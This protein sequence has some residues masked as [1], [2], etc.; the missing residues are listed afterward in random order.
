MLSFAL[1]LMLLPLVL[2]TT[3]AQPA[4]T[5]QLENVKLLNRLEA[6]LEQE[7]AVAQG[8]KKVLAYW[9]KDIC[10]PEGDD[11]NFDICGGRAGRE[12]GCPDT[13]EGRTDLCASGKGRKTVE[14]KGVIDGCKYLFY[15][16]YE[17]I[18]AKPK[19]KDC[20]LGDVPTAADCDASCGVVSQKIKVPAIGNGACKPQTYS[21]KPQDGNCPS[22]ALCYRQN[23]GAQGCTNFDD[24]LMSKTGAQSKDACSQNCAETRGCVG[25]EWEARFLGVFGEKAC[26]LLS[27]KCEAPELPDL[28]N[29]FVTDYNMEKCP[30]ACYKKISGKQGCLNIDK[31]KLKEFQVDTKQ[32]CANT[33]FATSDCVGFEWRDNIIGAKRLCTQLKGKCDNRRLFGPL[34]FNNFRVTDYTMEPCKV[35]ELTRAKDSKG[36]N[37]GEIPLEST[38]E[39]MSVNKALKEALAALTE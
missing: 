19:N 23:K 29:F 14:R 30:Q 24:I 22:D 10:G 25:F 39:L 16:E 37:V 9:D 26:S 15:A 8:E 11:K 17:C 31:I 32:I 7:A 2:S 20:V 36:L 6:L 13:F 4:R 34:G 3:Q 33:C 18:A 27:G 1:S 28:P 21:C 35:G 12:N 5:L 38:S